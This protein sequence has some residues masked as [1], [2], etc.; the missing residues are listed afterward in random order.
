M[1]KLMIIYSITSLN[2]MMSWICHIIKIHITDEY[3]INYV[4][5][6]RHRNTDEE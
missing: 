2:M 6:K 1:K 4:H 3:S 5:T